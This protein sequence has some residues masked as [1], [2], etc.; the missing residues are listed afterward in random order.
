MVPLR[1]LP[2]TARKIKPKKG[3]FKKVLNAIVL[4]FFCLKTVIT[5]N[6]KFI[7]VLSFSQKSTVFC[8]KKTMF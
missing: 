5:Q 4:I 2:V 8:E 7:L 6:I 1:S 3:T